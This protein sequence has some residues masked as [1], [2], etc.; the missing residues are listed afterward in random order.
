[1]NEHT[2]DW[3]RRVVRVCDCGPQQAMPPGPRPENPDRKPRSKPVPEGRVEEVVSLYRSGLTYQAIG[4]RYGVSRER[5]RQWIAKAVIG[6][7][8]KER[9]AARAQARLF[10]RCSRCGVEYEIARKAEHF[11]RGA[12]VDP[13]RWK[14]WAADYAAGMRLAD[15]M[16][17]WDSDATSIMR[18]V[19]A[20]GIPLRNPSIHRLSSTKV[21]ERKDRIRELAATGMAAKDIATAVSCSPSWVYLVLKET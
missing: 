1:M 17:K 16:S 11:I 12:H 5:V 9:F 4:Q 6:S 7:L 10:R 13:E 14:G 2:H 19:H 21:T 18:S 20:H 3:K 15:I 8:A